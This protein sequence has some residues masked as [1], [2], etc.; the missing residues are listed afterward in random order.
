MENQVIIL[1][2][3]KGTRMKSDKPKVLHDLAGKPMVDYVFEQAIK[4]SE[5]PIMVVGYMQEQV[6]EHLKNKSITFVSQD[7]QLGTGHAVACARE[8]INQEKSKNVFVIPGDHPLI[9]AETLEK[10]IAVHNSSHAIITIGTVKVPDFSGAYE[11]FLHSG[12]IVRDGS[13]NISEIVEYKDATEEQKKIK[14]VNVSYYCFNSAWLS[15]NLGL[16]ETLNVSQEYYITDLVKIA[17]SQKEKVS[18]FEIAQYFQAFG[19][20]TPGELKKMEMFL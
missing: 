17:S 1:A 5:K 6:R 13:G 4:I 8:Q 11:Q 12:R 16:L 7:K 20:N 10:I 3:G 19:A 2:A 14:E 18:S 15:A 9:K